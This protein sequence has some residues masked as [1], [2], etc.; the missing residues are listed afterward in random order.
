MRTTAE[1]GISVG[2]EEGGINREE[3]NEGGSAKDPEGVENIGADNV[4]E[5]HVTLAF[6]GVG[7]VG[8]ELGQGGADGD[9]GETDDD[10]EDVEI[11]RDLDGGFDETISADRDEGNAGDGDSDVVSPEADASERSR[12]LG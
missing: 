10:P 8:S 6:P 4:A 3:D 5:R 7:E 12:R 9:D 2:R 1:D 11:A